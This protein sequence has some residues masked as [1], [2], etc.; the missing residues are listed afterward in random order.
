MRKKVVSF[1]DYVFA[2]GKIRSLERFLIKDK[3]FQ[4]A[5]ESDLPDA[6]RLFVE[7]GLYDERLL[8]ISNPRDLEDFLGQQIIQLKGMVQGL[9]LDRALTGLLETNDLKKMQ[10][11]IQGYPSQFLKDYLR[12]LIDM[13][14]I[15]TFLRLYTLKEPEDKLKACL[16]YE[17]FIK[18]ED[19][20]KLYDQDLSVFIKQLEYVR[21]E[22]LLIDYALYLREAIQKIERLNSFVF[23]EKAIQDFLVQKLQAAKYIPL[24]PEPVL[25]YYFAK[26]NELN[27]IRMII[28]A[29]FNNLSRDFIK[30]RLNISYA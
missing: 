2:I 23:L 20:F 28:L 11:A 7:A 3:V 10:E 25:A 18:K 30:E 16:T 12:Y 22:N 4:E 17:G 27:T 8:G 5:I 6:L 1:F 21:T 15:K 26:L 14:N 29:K 9:I 13:H 19:F 24:G